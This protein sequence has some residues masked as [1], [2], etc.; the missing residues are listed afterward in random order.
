MT[1]HKREFWIRFDDLI[2][3]SER[4]LI[5]VCAESG[6]PYDTLITQRTRKSIPKVEQ[7]ID[8]A[9]A[10]GVSL[11]RLVIGKEFKEDPIAKSINE[12]QTLKILFSRI[13]DCTPVQRKAIGVMLDTWG[14]ALYQQ[15][16]RESQIL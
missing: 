7:L 4:K 9:V 10:L 12:D 8:M 11:D 1:I 16:N 3:K 13:I 15:K 5:D 6:I 2:K 14:I